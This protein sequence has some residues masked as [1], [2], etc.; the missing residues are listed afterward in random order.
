MEEQESISNSNIMRVK[1]LQRE[2]ELAESRAVEAESSL[3]GFR[4]RQRVYSAAE[5]MR[6]ESSVEEVDRQIV[7]KKV[8]NNS[9]V[10]SSKTAQISSSMAESSSSAMASSRQQA[11]ASSSSMSR[12]YRAGSTTAA[13]AGS[14]SYSRAGSMARSSAL[15]AT[16]MARGSSIG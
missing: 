12:D 2:L 6:R 7:I 5:S 8:V 1:K 11:L 9:N 10:S 4:S 14:S 16:S 15:R 3:N 13:L